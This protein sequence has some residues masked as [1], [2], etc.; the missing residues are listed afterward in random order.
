MTVTASKLWKLF[1]VSMDRPKLMKNCGNCRQFPPRGGS[2]KKVAKTSGQFSGFCL[3]FAR[4][5]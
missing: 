3:A 4:A 5:P 1:L 2:C